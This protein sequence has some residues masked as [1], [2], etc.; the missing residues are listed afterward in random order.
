MAAFKLEN[1][2]NYTV[3]AFP[4]P[5]VSELNLTI[6]SNVAGNAVIKMMDMRGRALLLKPAKIESGKNQ[7]NIS[8]LGV[9]AHGMYVVEVSLNGKKLA[10]KVVKQ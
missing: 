1:A 7:V 10:E 3:K 2:N 5:F 8:N 9:L 4:N 6:T